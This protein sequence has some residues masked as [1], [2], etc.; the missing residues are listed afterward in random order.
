MAPRREDHVS[1]YKG[2]NYDPNYQRRQPHREGGPLNPSSI[3]K[4]IQSGGKFS[5]SQLGQHAVVH[6][7][8]K[9]QLGGQPQP[10]QQLQQ[11][12]QQQQRQR[13]QR[14]RSRDSWEQLQPPK[15][16]L[17]FPQKQPYQPFQPR[18]QPQYQ[19]Q[20]P[21]H[22]PFQQPF[23]Q[24]FYKKEQQQ[25]QP[26][27]SPPPPYPGPHQG[28]SLRQLAAPELIANLLDVFENELTRRLRTDHDGDAIMC[29]CAPNHY[30][31]PQNMSFCVHAQA[32]E[33]V[34]M[35]GQYNRLHLDVINLLGHFCS[36][37]P[38]VQEDLR[39]WTLEF[40]Q[41][42][43]ESNLSVLLQQ[44]TPMPVQ[45]QVPQMQQEQYDGIC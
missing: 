27:T 1:N 12:L 8:K 15:Q 37:G 42:N 3:L 26:C 32:R 34:W 7:P 41:E 39:D 4:N 35:S 44:G 18:Q 21:F 16:P 43:P 11:Q 45:G 22:N 17:H 36:K 20:Q 13:Y 19:R 23:Q 33:Y 14:H 24:P 28:L 30:T 25:Q 31:T 6:P 9:A 2:R 38:E 5:P 40:M 10:F 29:D